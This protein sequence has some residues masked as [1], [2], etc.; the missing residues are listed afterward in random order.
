MNNLPVA[1][2]APPPRQTRRLVGSSGARRYTPLPSSNGGDSVARPG[3]GGNSANSG[4][5]RYPR[6]SLGCPARRIC[7][8][9]GRHG[10][11]GDS[12]ASSD[13]LPQTSVI[14]GC[15]SRPKWERVYVVGSAISFGDDIASV[16]V[17]STNANGLHNSSCKASSSHWPA[18]RSTGAQSSGRSQTLPPNQHDGGVSCDGTSGAT[19]PL[20]LSLPP[21]LYFH[22]RG[23]YFS[24]GRERPS[25]LCVWI[26][27]STPEAHATQATPSSRLPTSWPSCP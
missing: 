26:Y 4:S 18:Q 8:A 1:S 17:G 7:G 9:C 12:V 20:V 2:P 27:S 21:A 22:R 24:R 11:A 10:F 16:G 3:S 14:F 19:L 13:T 5:T 25:I 23:S 6:R 15:C